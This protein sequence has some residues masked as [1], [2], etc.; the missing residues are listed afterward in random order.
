MAI[1]MGETAGVGVSQRAGQFVRF[2]GAVTSLALMA[3]VAVWGYSL[4]MRDVTGVPVVRA[5][6]GPMRLA[7]ENPGGAVTDYEGL[8]VNAVAAKG[9]A[10][11][12][13]DV[14]LL[15]PPTVQLSQ[16]DLEAQPVAEADEI[17]PSPFP[18]LPADAPEAE[19]A[20][21]LD[22]VPEAASPVLSEP[23]AVAPQANAP[24]TPDDIL[25]LAD[26]IAAGAA[27]LTA[28]PEGTPVP[29]VAMAVNGVSVEEIADIVPASVPGVSKSPRPPARPA[30][31]AVVPSAPEQGTVMASAATSPAAPPAPNVVDPA[32]IPVGTHLVQLGAF[33]S[34]QVAETEWTRLRAAFPDYLAEK[35]LVIQKASSG[36]KTF[37][38]L[39]AM[40]FAD[41]ADTNRF[42]AA[43]VAENAIC[44]PVEVR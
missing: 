30:G 7:P 34:P 27:P 42:C 1:Q 13:E 22:P 39:R 15:A 8:A 43:L 12:P 23:V 19:V 3:G 21:A 44:I 38:R 10:E 4:I 18:T 24:L 16:D 37:Y 17:R 14:V 40:G 33:D 35:T 11:A 28:L 26:Q 5:M 41:R 29:E 36:G 20:T 2:A 31:L 9:E 25:A 32:T 6:E